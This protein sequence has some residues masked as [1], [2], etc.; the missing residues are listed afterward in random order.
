MTG[1]AGRFGSVVTAMVTPFRDDDHAVD[2]DG[3]QQL[4]SWLVDN[5]SDAIVA[6]GSTG[7]SPTLSAKEKSELFRAV[8]EA[9]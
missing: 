8:G 9:I 3:A 7:E 5:G 1:H 2:L 4:A 6:T